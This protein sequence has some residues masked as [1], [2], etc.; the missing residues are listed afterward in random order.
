MKETIEA[1][2]EARNKCADTV[3]K[4]TLKEIDE[5]INS[6]EKKQEGEPKSNKLKLFSV[7]IKVFTLIRLLAG[8]VDGD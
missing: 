7:A 6:L 5:A 4:S 2:K 8:D 3:D 1:L